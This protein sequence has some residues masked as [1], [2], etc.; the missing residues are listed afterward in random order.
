MIDA[1]SKN[2]LSLWYGRTAVQHIRPV[3]I[4]ALT[5]Q[6]YWDKWDRVSC[7]QLQ[8]IARRFFERLWQVETPD[9][10][11]LL[12]DTTDY[13]TFMSSSTPSDSARRGK[14]KGG[15]ALSAAGRPR[16]SDGA[17]QQASALLHRL[18]RQ[19]A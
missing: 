10:D 4:K 7:E 2:K 17:Q 15:E 19:S 8:T 18:S 11:C 5:S 12:F 3:D 16:S 14:N 9:A 1:V 6:R 13:Y